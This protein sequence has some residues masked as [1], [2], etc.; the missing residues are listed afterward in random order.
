MLPWNTLLASAMGAAVPLIPIYIFGFR[1]TLGAKDA[2]I[3]SLR[4][5]V[6]GLERERVAVI[7]EEEQVLLKDIQSR[8]EE[9]KES[10]R[11]I[12]E[13]SEKIE[14]LVQDMQN[15]QAEIEVHA[16]AIGTLSPK[17][18]EVGIAF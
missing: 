15:T 1:Q 3:E 5:Q 7:L 18:Q 10:D 14:A 12:T 16:A 2:V 8:A 6:K 9:K 17:I 11:A 4:E 13:M